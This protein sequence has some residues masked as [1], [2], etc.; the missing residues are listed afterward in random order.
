MRSPRALSIRPPGGAKA[1]LGIGLA[2]VLGLS[3]L[4]SAGA[5]SHREAPLITEDPVSDNTDVYAFVA[6]DAPDSVTL[7]SNFQGYQA[8]GGGPNYFRFGDDVLY[9]IHVDNDGDA[10]PDVTYEFRFTTTTVNPD[11]FLY[12]TG[13]I[14]DIEGSEWNRPQEYTVSRVEGG[15]RTV[16]ASG[17]RTPPVNAGPRSTPDY[18]NLA[19]QAIHDL[20]GGGKVFAGQRAEGFYGDVSAIFDLGGLRP[21]NEA[22]AI[23]LPNED[24]VDIFSGYNVQSIA[25]QVPKADL[26]TAEEPVI[27]VWSTASRRKVRVFAQDNSSPPAHRGKWVQVSRLGSPLVNEAV[28]P[29]GLKD[30]FNTLQP[31]QDAGAL[32]QPD[33][34]NG[35]TIPLVQEPELA[36]RIE[37]LYGVDTPP[38]PRN[39]L[40]AIFLTGI[41]GLNQPANVQPAEVLRLNTSIEPTPFA[42]QDRL[43][44]LAG[45]NDGYPNGR[46]PVDD[47]VDIALRAVAGGTPFTPDFN[48]APNN[49]LG[50]GV[51]GST[52]PFLESFPYLGTPYQGYE[53]GGGPTSTP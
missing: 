51:D 35:V 37:G 48:V 38:A 25:I 7:I 45:Q 14:S 42:D 29:L 26:V 27:G 16:V 18:E 3:L 31:A 49:A 10:Q 6:P 4:A 8:P 32:S 23:P 13:P 19:A 28:I 17:L 1:M 43:G 30:V 36:A 11:T 52:Q 44:L 34:G 21:L 53:Y 39:D 20:P 46:R 12:A 40:V 50:D 9:S 33:P 47:V 15:Q 2:A 22:H 41:E 5:S 24:G